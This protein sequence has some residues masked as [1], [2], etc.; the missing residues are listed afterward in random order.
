MLGG[1]RWVARLVIVT[2]G[3]APMVRNDPIG[4]CAGRPERDARGPRWEARPVTVTA[5]EAPMVRNDRIR[6]CVGRPEQDARGPRWVVRPV[7]VTEGEAPMVRND[8]IRGCVGRPGQPWSDDRLPPKRFS[9]TAR[10]PG[11]V[12]TGGAAVRLIAGD[13][14]RLLQ[15]GGVAGPAR[16]TS[17]RVRRRAADRRSPARHKIG[18]RGSAGGPHVATVGSQRPRRGC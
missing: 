14:M 6:G 2:E 12:G 9:S 13:L 3:E 17:W 15:A 8:P 10:P 18:P 4:G 11:V 16:R 1:P 7:T 5:G